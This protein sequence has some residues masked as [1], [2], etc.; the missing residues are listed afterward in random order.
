MRILAVSM[1]AVRRRVRDHTVQEL[2]DVLT[3]QQRQIEQQR[4]ELD[5][6][7]RRIAALNAALPLAQD[8]DETPP[9]Y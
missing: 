8:E 4:I 3:Q 5:D 1:G 7:R 9:H 6:L 2:N